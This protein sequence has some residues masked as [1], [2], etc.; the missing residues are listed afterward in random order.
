M[1]SPQSRFSSVK[2]VMRMQVEAVG[3]LQVICAAKFSKFS[4]AKCRGQSIGREME[5]KVSNNGFNQAKNN[6][7]IFFLVLW[8]HIA[9]WPIGVPAPISDMHFPCHSKKIA[10]NRRQF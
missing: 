4:A 3:V 9:F 2:S 6:D 7:P 1:G 10:L 5:T 8:G